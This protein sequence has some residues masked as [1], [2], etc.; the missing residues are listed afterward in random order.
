MCLSQF[1]YNIEHVKGTHNLCAKSLSNTFYEQETRNDTYNFVNVGVT[2]KNILNNEICLLQHFLDLF[3]LYLGSIVV[4]NTLR[5]FLLQDH[6]SMP[7]RDI[8]RLKNVK[9]L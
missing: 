8:C 6:L 7:K 2:T 5:L 9:G 4:K 3:E 1:D